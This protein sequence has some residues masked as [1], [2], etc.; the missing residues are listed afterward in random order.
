MEYF[1]VVDGIQPPW[2]LNLLHMLPLSLNFNLRDNANCEAKIMAALPNAPLW[3]YRNLKKR[4]KDLF[5]GSDNVHR[6]PPA[7][8]PYIG[9]LRNIVQCNI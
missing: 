5:D 8:G 3:H 2:V 6:G 1:I 4:S 9:R 7:S